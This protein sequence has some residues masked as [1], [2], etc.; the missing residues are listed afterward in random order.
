MIDRLTANLRAA[1][2]LF[3]TEDERLPTRLAGSR[4]GAFRNLEVSATGVVDF[5]R[6]RSG[7][8]DTAETS[9]LHLDAL[10]HASS[11]STRIW[12]HRGQRIQCWR[13]R[14]RLL[15]SRLR[16][17]DSSQPLSDVGADEPPRSSVTE[18]TRPMARSAKKDGLL[19]DLPKAGNPGP[20]LN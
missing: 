12:L 15:P 13:A 18:R 14:A 19:A 9:S 1:A 7:R 3:M 16:Q 11:R 4:K 5:E 6:L 2:S 17:D 20:V 10:R 8:V